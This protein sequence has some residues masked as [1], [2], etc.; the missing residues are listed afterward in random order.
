MADTAV[1]RVDVASSDFDKF[2][3]SFNQ[4]AKTLESTLATWSKITTE[5]K[6]AS[7]A[8]TN[9][10]APVARSTA[11][12]QKFTQQ[13]AE[14]AKHTASIRTNVDSISKG[15][16]SW[17]TAIGSTIALLGLGGGLA[18]LT[19]L[20]AGVSNDRARAL[21]SGVGYGQF[22]GLNAGSFPGAGA[23]EQ[24]W[25][26]A[27]YDATSAARRGAQTIFGSDTQRQLDRTDPLA[28]VD[29]LNKATQYLK[30]FP[31]A[32]R[33][34]IAATTGLT[35]FLGKDALRTW[36]NLTEEEVRVRTRA[37]KAAGDQ[38]KAAEE[39]VKKWTTFNIALEASKSIIQDVLVDRLAPL[40]GP[41]T[42]L[43][44]AMNEAV[45]AFLDAPVIKK[46]I[47]DAAQSI[48]EFATYLN[49]P[50]TKKAIEDFAGELMAAYTTIKN[51][52]EGVDNV[53]N[54]ILDAQK[55]FGETMQRFWSWVGSFLPKGESEQAGQ[56]RKSEEKSSKWFKSWTQSKD[57]NNLDAAGDIAIPPSVSG[58]S[59]KPQAEV[60]GATGM[61]GGGSYAEW[62][63]GWFVQEQQ[64][65]K[66]AARS[67]A[68]RDET[69]QRLMGNLDNWFQR[70]GEREDKLNST[71]E[72]F[73]TFLKKANVTEGT[74]GA[75]AGG[76]GTMT[77]G[78]GGASG[79]IRG[80][81]SG[82]GANINAPGRSVASG[83]LAK[84][85][86]EAYEA[87]KASGLSDT[88][89]RALVANMSGEALGDPSNRTGDK[90][91]AQGIVQWHADRA[92]AIR[93][94]FGK[95]PA[96]MSVADQTKAAIW[97]MQTNPAYKQSWAALQGGGSAESM[98]GTLVSN[99]ER[100]ANVGKS[101]AERERF[102][103]GLNV[104]GDASANS[105]S[106]IRGPGGGNAA[107][108]S[109]LLAEVKKTHPHLT[110]EQCV[111][112]VKE[113]TGM[114][115]T[116]KDWRKGSS[117]M[118]GNMKIGTPIATFMSSQGQQSDRYDAGGIGTPGA[119]T[120]HA[121]LFGG[122]TRDQSGKITGINVVEQY[123]YSGRKGQVQGPHIQHYGIG[124]FGEHGAENYF[125]IASAGGGKRGKLNGLDN[126]NWQQKPI[127]H[128]Q[129]H[130]KSGSDVH[131]AAS[132]INTST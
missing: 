13:F 89:A 120:S 82:A 75:A 87:A 26:S 69:T 29:A 112:L 30:Q 19:S 73:D 32:L 18:G 9:M 104:G 21:A 81:T 54:N 115:G 14:T 58:G 92:A 1:L 17:R 131:I 86:K 39:S 114:G 34:T 111:T 61:L 107:D 105:T 28:M 63:K 77:E 12:L 119:G 44:M 3:A 59:G 91:K 127:N 125:G 38:A 46:A 52:S 16:V 60:M 84:N 129:I 90:G 37:I 109:A 118:S 31:P 121:A 98:V 45:K 113:F 24:G 72:D 96:D 126:D 128:V 47:D 51:F 23:A 53:L 42:D 97:E 56:I 106:D 71:L 68:S 11:S 79:G 43:S 85:Q 57:Q 108:A 124:G 123:K 8:M 36:Q 33:D 2:Q 78:A 35:D 116:V 40:A 122:Y 99:Y 4:Y 22:R 5:V 41:L 100:P 83:N 80:R 65:T 20:V 102:L 101:T 15:L 70:A 130:N 64:S 110:N 95:D 62:F 49:Q 76:E 10:V 93:A 55:R 50:E 117:V 27:R 94:H 74:G 6:A 66:E 7:A 103:H 25:G 88:A 48:N 67:A 132:T